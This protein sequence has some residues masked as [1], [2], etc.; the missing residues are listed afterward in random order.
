MLAL[1]ACATQT[2]VTEQSAA[3][4]TQQSVLP[5]P[6]AQ[7]ISSIERVTPLE[8]AAFWN[9]QYNIHPTDL[10]I[11]LAYVDAL[12]DI[13]SFDRA[14]EV[15]KFTSISFPDEPAVFMVLGKAHTRNDNAVEAIRAYSRVIDLDDA[16]PAPL[17]A[18]G[19]IFDKRGDHE[20][21]QLAYTRALA[22]DPDRAI[23]LANYGLSLSLTGELEA[24]EEALRKAAS[25]P[26]VTPAIRQNHALILGLMGR[27]E[28]ARTLAAIDA[29]GGIAEQNTQL[30][31][32]FIG[33]H[34]KLKAVSQKTVAKTLSSKPEIITETPTPA[35][36]QPIKTAALED[37]VTPE[38][39]ITEPET[40][41]VNT[42]SQNSTSVDGLRL[43]TRK[44]TSGGE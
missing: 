42:A 39:K 23:T 4:A 30:L 9:E 25:L 7:M 26:E 11:S 12:T 32:D 1:G 10:D 18:L 16:D 29:P 44:R 31:Q 22:I 43:R 34:A 28:E 20:N 24:A 27:F 19:V 41:T 15:A 33:E 40:K 6:T 2:V 8:R 17:A 38:A 3:Q 13:K 14:A 35:P 21:A 36:R 5:K 37:L